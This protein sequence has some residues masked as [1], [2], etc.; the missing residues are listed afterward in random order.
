VGRKAV[1]LTDI[2]EALGVEPASG[3]GFG[4][5]TLKAE[6]KIF[7][8]ESGGRLVL[9]LPAARVSALIAAG[10]GLP[11]DAGKGK[12]MKEWVALD[13]AAALDHIAL[14]REAHAFVAGR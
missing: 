5:G 3:K 6:N 13:P 12:Q 8:M 10:D 1:T 14:A 9:K 2:A 7:A 4:S 11:F